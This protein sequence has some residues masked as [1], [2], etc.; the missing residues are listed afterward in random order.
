MK[1]L[2]VIWIV[3]CTVLSGCGGTTVDE[4]KEGGLYSTQ[5][6]DGSYSVL[7]IL[8]VD[9]HGVHVRLYSNQ[10]SQR[11]NDVDSNTLYMAGI[12]RKPDER[13][14]MG[15]LPISKASFSSWG[16]QY[17]KTVPVTDDELEGYRMWLDAEGGYF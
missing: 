17:I 14:G 12:D 9:D 15:H 8:K 10:F 7:K 11:P 1:T 3:A 6:D 13:L 5:N 16:A 2:I 4:W